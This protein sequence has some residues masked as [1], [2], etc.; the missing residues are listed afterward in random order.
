MQTAGY[1]SYRTISTETASPGAL[2][3]QLYQA[4]IRNAGQAQIAIG[5]HDVAE[6]HAR[7]MR[8]Q[9]IVAELRRT[10][11]FEQGG[12]IATRL[13]ALYDYMQGRL[14]QANIQK[15]VTPLAEVQ[16]LLRQLLAAWQ[17]AVQKSTQAG[18]PAQAPA[19]S[20]AAAA[21][22]RALNAMVG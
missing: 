12:E 7:I 21:P 5:K 19:V 17:V 6:A 20:P 10:L 4:A 9:E 13:A 1:T 2:L 18:S 11:D 22:P 15:D 8:M 3:L 14:I 16:G